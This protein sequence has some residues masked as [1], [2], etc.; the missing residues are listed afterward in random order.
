M[1]SHRFY[2]PRFFHIGSIEEM[3][4]PLFKTRHAANAHRV[5]WLR[6]MHHRYRAT[7][8]QHAVV[9][10]RRLLCGGAVVNLLREGVA[11]VPQGF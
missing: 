2:H 6:A 11:G 9:Y 1:Y 4:Q 10:R 8:A 5:E 7:G 3:E